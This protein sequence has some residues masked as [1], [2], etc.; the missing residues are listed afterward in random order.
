[1]NYGNWKH[2]LGV[3]KVWKQSYDGIFVNTHIM[4]DS[5]VATFD[6]TLL[7][8]FFLFFFTF[9]SSFSICYFFLFFSSFLPFSSQFIFFFFLFAFLI[10]IHFFFR[11]SHLTLTKCLGMDPTKSWNIWVMWNENSVSNEWSLENLGILNDKWWVTKINQTAPLLTQI[12][13]M[14][15]SLISSL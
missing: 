4:R 3:F 5:P 7:F 15:L 14:F 8:F 12:T 10:S 1:M 13:D 2:I 6:F 9:L 11:L